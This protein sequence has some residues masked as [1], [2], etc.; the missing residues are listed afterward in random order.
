M[1]IDLWV[2]YFS[3][4]FF[5]PIPIFPKKRYKKQDKKAFIFPSKPLFVFFNAVFIKIN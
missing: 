2:S 3:G 5:H 4:L 1:S